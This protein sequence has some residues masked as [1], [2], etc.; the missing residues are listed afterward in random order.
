MRRE[1]SRTPSLKSFVDGYAPNVCGLWISA[2][3][4][5]GVLGVL[6]SVWCVLGVLGV[7]CVRCLV[8]GVVGVL[9]VWLGGPFFIVFPNVKLNLGSVRCGGTNRPQWDL[10]NKN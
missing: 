1:G 10:Y 2:G 8:V 6:G 3:A 7:R 5:F 9:C 4:M